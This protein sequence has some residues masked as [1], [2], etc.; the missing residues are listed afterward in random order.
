M[1][2]KFEILTTGKVSNNVA[3]PVTCVGCG[4]VFKYPLSKVKEHPQSEHYLVHCTVK[5]PMEGCPAQ[6]IISYGTS[7]F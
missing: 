3:G 7:S 1:M 6:A 2:N 5:C 4:C